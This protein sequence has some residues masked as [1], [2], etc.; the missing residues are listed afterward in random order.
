MSCIVNTSLDLIRTAAGET[1]F[2][3]DVG[4][5][6]KADVCVCVLVKVH[7]TAEDAIIPDVCCHRWLQHPLAWEEPS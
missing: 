4:P 5:E 3:L 7:G 6:Q 2:L 1:I